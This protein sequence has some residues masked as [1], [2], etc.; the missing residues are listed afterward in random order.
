[1]DLKSMVRD[2][3]DFPKPGILFKDITPVLQDQTAFLQLIDML[4]HTLRGYAVE[5][6]VAPEA[7]G[8][9][10]GAPLAYALG[11]GF[12]PL[13]KPGKLPYAVNKIS[14]ALEYGEN[15]MEIHQDAVLPNQRI[16][17][18]DDL[19]ATGGTAKAA[20]DVGE[21]MGARIVAVRFAFALDALGGEAL[22]KGYDVMSLI[23]YE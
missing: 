5:A 1:M 3:Q 9:M 17:V 21:S 2:I 20:C 16:A 22:L 19:L 12:V 13:R 7:R 18:V 8:F 15:Q 10:L 11:V 6:I 14:Y 4:A 23:H